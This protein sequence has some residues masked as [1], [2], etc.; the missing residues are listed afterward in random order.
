MAR[1]IEAAG[2]VAIFVCGRGER[3]TRCHYCSRPHTMLCDFVTGTRVEGICTINE[4][5]DRRL[6]GQCA[7]VVGLDISHCRIHRIR[8]EK[9][10]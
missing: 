3:P 8:G 6:C 4:T 1:I 9:K 2:A 7:D 10:P 5:C